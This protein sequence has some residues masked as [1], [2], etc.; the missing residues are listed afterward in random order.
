MSASHGHTIEEIKAEGWPIY[1]RVEVR[2]EGDT[3]ESVA[4]AM[5]ECTSAMAA[6]L[7][8]T[9]PDILIVL[10]DRSEMHAAALAGLPFSIP[11]AHIHGGELSLGSLD[12][13]FRHS[14]TKL[15]HLHFP[16]TAS[17]AQRI[18]QM[19]EEPW[20]VTVAGA[21]ALD[22]FLIEE[23]LSLGEVEGSFGIDLSSAPV[24]VTLHPESFGS[25]KQ[26]ELA[27]LVASALSK[28]PGPIIITAPNADLGRDDI[29]REMQV[30][31]ATRSDIFYIDSL[32]ARAYRTVLER[33][34]F[35][36][37]NSSS[38]LI[39]AAS[40][41]LPVVNIG[42]RQAAR[43]RPANVIDVH[44][45]AEAL[46]QAIG[47]AESDRFRATLADL[48][49][50]YGNGHACERIVDVVRSVP[51]DRRLLVKRFRDLEMMQ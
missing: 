22:A 6:A 20:R 17:Y 45:D 51:L 14:L 35:M 30:F 26:S 46:K 1:A 15:S 43:I 32:G 3:P 21:P 41:K 42:D 50:P 24:L 10:G 29:A 48:S 18:L 8:K 5:G 47:T 2:M 49:N 23:P 33:S 12:D 44:A 31:A 7:T 34:R 40:F 39:E 28:V 13:T 27:R 16:A 4:R 11:I 38:G 19:G 25:V 37:G 9:R 36:I